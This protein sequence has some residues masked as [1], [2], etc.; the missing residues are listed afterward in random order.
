MYQRERRTRHTPLVPRPQ[1]RHN[2][3]RQ[4]RL[5]APQ[6]ARQEHQQRRLQPAGKF[7]A[8]R[9]RLFRRP[10]HHALGLAHSPLF[11]HGDADAAKIPSSSVA[12]PAPRRSPSSP[13][14]PPILIPYPPPP[15]ANTR[16][17]L[18]SATNRPS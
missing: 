18:G 7:P 3:L 17:G 2:P 1:P 14:S 9:D 16:Q 5:P 12:A 13:T 11:T 10:R 8:P 4:R 6:T 15:R